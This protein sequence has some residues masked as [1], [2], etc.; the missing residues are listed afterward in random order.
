[1]GGGKFLSKA[2]GQAGEGVGW[3]RRALSVSVSPEFVPTGVRCR[4]AEGPSSH[5][6]GAGLGLRDPS[7]SQ[8][9]SRMGEA[10]MKLEMRLSLP[11]KGAIKPCQCVTLAF[12][13]ITLI[14]YMPTCAWSAWH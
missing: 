11:D 6:L 4:G 14:Y 5:Y 10:R 8:L 13:F 7:P 12:I 9:S 1:M 2:V 3:A